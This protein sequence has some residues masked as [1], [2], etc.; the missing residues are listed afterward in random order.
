MTMIIA[1]VALQMRCDTG[2]QKLHTYRRW[3]EIDSKILFRIMHSYRENARSEVQTFKYRA[4]LWATV[5]TPTPAPTPPG[6]D[7][8]H[9]NTTSGYSSSDSEQ[10]SSPAPSIG[11]STTS[12]PP[13]KGEAI[14]SHIENH[15][16]DLVTTFGLPRAT[17][18][19]AIQAAELGLTCG[20]GRTTVVQGQWTQG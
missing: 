4:M 17:R 2:Y 1:Q 10:L 11:Y 16:V 9:V 12:D 5:G 13:L 14:I 8:Q 6:E 20:Q 3:R 15:E 7:A 18:A 19:R